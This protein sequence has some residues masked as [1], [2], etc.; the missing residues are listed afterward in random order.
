[1]K[2]HLRVLIVEDS[3]DDMLLMLR[4][5]KRGGYTLD[6]T[7]VDTPASMQAALERQEWDIAIADYTLPA[8]SAPEALKLLQSQGLDIP[9]IIVSGTIGE[10]IAVAA[11]KAGAHDYI[12]KGNLTRLLPA[13]ERELREAEERCKRRSAELAL[14][15]SEER[16]R[17]Q[18]GELADAN[19]ALQDYADELTGQLLI[20]PSR[21]RCCHAGGDNEVQR[22]ML[23][24]VNQLDGFDSRGNI[25]VKSSCSCS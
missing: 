6:Y 23:E 2:L 18:A 7:R 9:F 16:I 3:E 4:E 14:K 5:L 1:M 15:Q 12:I 17:I 21:S 25:K 19:N 8:F 11:M 20:S 13:V 24:I 10:E 22:T